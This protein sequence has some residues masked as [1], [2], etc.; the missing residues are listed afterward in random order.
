[1]R[2]LASALFLAGAFLNSTAIAAPDDDGEIRIGGS[3]T[4]LPVVSA[5]ASEFMEKYGT[6]DKVDPKLPGK[7]IVI[8]LTGGGSGFGI[9]STIQGVNHIGLVSRD[10]KDKEKELLGPHRATLIGKDA[11][12]FVTNKANPLAQKKLSLSKAQL[13]SVFSGDIKTY[14]DIDRALPA[15]SVVVFVRDS[16]AGSAE[17]I[18][19]TVMGDK[20]VSKNALQLP[21]QGALLKKIESNKAAVA[22][23]SAGLISS[24]N[25]LHP[26][27]YEGVLPSPDKIINGEY[28]LSRPLLL[29][30]K[31]PHSVMLD[32]FIN[33]LLA[34]G[35]KIL[36]ENGYIPVKPGAKPPS[37]KGK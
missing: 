4:L 35:Q 29:L 16:G 18:Q 7:K 20:Q 15:S 33:Y 34:D 11:V 26:L 27:A 32:H 36:Q 2:I 24:S 31:E 23:I 19:N 37:A 14:R 25:K 5:A 9:Q 6:W 30:V 1:M 28:K 21:S 10:L 12:A 13:A 17:V 22:Y 8:Y 3:T